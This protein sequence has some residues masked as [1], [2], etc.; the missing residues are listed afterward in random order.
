M[1]DLVIRPSIKGIIVWYALSALLVIAIVIFLQSRA[2][3]PPELWSLMVI[4]LALDLWASLKHVRLNTRRIT[5]ENGVLRYEDG[6]VGK[7]QRNIMLDKVRDVRMEQ[8]LGQRLVGV[9]DLCV[10][11]LGDSGSITLENVDRPREIADALVAAMR[12]FPRNQS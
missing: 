4:P 1:A 12:N 7:T 8:T 5:L 11:A 3:Q 10:E 9:G 6:L 2:F